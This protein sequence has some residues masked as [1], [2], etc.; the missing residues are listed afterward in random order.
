MRTLCSHVFLRFPSKLH[1]GSVD[2]FIR[3]WRV[4]HRQNSCWKTN[5]NI[6]VML[7]NF[8]CCFIRSKIAV[9]YLSSRE[10]W[11]IRPRCFWSAHAAK[12]QPCKSRGLPLILTIKGFL[13]VNLKLHHPGSRPL[14]RSEGPRRKQKRLGTNR[15]SWRN[16]SRWICRGGFRTGLPRNPGNTAVRSW[17]ARGALSHRPLSHRNKWCVQSPT[18]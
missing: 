10:Y 18:F 8:F 13:S 2:E 15:R 5:L 3:F 17:N 1:S 16:L 7:K 12:P 4:V 9:N 11:E 14:S 6:S